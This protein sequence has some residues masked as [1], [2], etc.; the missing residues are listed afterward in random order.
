MSTRTLVCSAIV[1]PVRN[2]LPSR[3]GEVARSLRSTAP[4]T[5]AS[6]RHSCAAA[7]VQQQTLAKLVRGQG[8]QIAARATA[9]R[10][11]YGISPTLAFRRKAEPTSRAASVGV[12]ALAELRCRSA[13]RT[14]GADLQARIGMNDRSAR[15]VMPDVL[16]CAEKFEIVRVVIQP[17][18]V[19]VVDKFRP[20]DRTPELPFHDEPVQSPRP[21]SRLH[22]QIARVVHV[23]AWRAVLAALDPGHVAVLAPPH[24]VGVAPGS[25]ADGL[26]AIRSGTR[27]HGASFTP[28]ARRAQ[29]GA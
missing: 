9:S 14:S 17:V 23:D 2:G 16:G 7:S 18:L 24:V 1:A 5:P 11:G 8:R 6:R 28:R 20:S 29:E 22:E 13:L 25:S 12:V 21:P 26:G 4:E 15:P 3:G 27:F 10:D 19:L